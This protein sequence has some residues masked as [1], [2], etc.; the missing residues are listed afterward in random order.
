MSAVANWTVNR[1]LLASGDVEGEPRRALFHSL[2]L[3]HRRRVVVFQW[4][5]KH[6]V[7][8]VSMR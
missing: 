3:P 6:G 2:F 1:S 5:P 8:A 4:Q 7:A